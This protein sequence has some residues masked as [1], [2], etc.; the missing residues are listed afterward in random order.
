[1]MCETT[2]KP[3]GELGKVINL[4]IYEKPYKLDGIPVGLITAEFRKRRCQGEGVYSVRF[5]DQR[6][7][8]QLIVPVMSGVIWDESTGDVRLT[9]M[10]VDPREVLSRRMTEF[11]C[12]AASREVKTAENVCM[13]REGN[14]S[15]L[16]IRCQHGVVVSGWYDTHTEE[17]A[18]GMKML[19]FILQTLSALNA[20]DTVLAKAA[21]Q[22]PLDDLT[23]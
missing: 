18:N 14:M 11:Y 23:A 22:K 16:A 21:A 10:P 15:F 2:K 6:I 20:H 1:M 8:A 4:M 9:K 13:L 7:A 12:A 17:S 3:G 5:Y 19:A